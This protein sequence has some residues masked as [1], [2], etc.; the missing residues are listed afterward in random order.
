MLIEYLVRETNGYLTLHL[1]WQR[2]ET[3]FNVKRLLNPCSTNTGGQKTR[4]VIL[5]CATLFFAY[6]PK[7]KK[8]CRLS[9]DEDLFTRVDNTR[10]FLSGSSFV[11]INFDRRKRMFLLNWHR[12]NGIKLCNL[13][14]KY[15]NL[16]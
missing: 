12:I 5:Y 16:P 9:P 11:W 1:I 8:W 7:V 4:G 2:L 14:Q 10:A 15:L 3:R 13:T 6:F